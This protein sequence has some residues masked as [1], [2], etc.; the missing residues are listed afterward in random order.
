MIDI[1][2]TKEGDLDLSN[3][4]LNLVDSS[5][6]IGQNMAIRLR[7]MLAEWFLD[8]T[9]GIPYYEEILVKSPNQNRVETILKDEIIN[10][11]GVLELISFSA[12]YNQ[13]Q[14]KYTAEFTARLISG[15][16]LEQDFELAI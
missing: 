12:Q 9:Q 15:E 11:D 16:T 13:S 14:R 1:A 4:D 10:T 3:L 5:L 2:L 6:Q 7:F 8:I